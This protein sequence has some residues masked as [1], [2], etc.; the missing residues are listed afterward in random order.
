MTNKQLSGLESDEITRFFCRHLVGL[1]VTYQTKTSDDECQLNHSAVISGTLIFIEQSLMFLTAGHVLEKLDM[2]RSS[3]SAEVTSSCLIDTQGSQSVSGVP[4]PFELGSA[5][6][7]YIDNEKRALDFGV[8][9]LSPYYGRL[10]AANGMVALTEK[11]WSQQDQLTFDYHAVLGFLKE[12][13]SAYVSVD[14]HIDVSPVLLGVRKLED[15]PN[16]SVNGQFIGQIGP[17]Q[18]KSVKGMSGGPIFGFQLGPKKELR[19]WVVALQSS[20]NPQT[21]VIRGCSLPVL[22]TLMT[23]AAR[24]VP[25]T[26]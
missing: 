11:Q 17:D 4:I 9:S 25:P 6:F 12:F 10:L 22:A 7:F 2:L 5:R 14:G 3:D 16:K 21:R 15:V 19:Y 18:P 20:W 1:C 23:E 26:P 24:N 13:V 8:V